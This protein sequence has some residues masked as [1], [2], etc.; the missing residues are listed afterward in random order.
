M[1]R[2]QICRKIKDTFPPIMNIN[3]NGLRNT[4]KEESDASLARELQSTDGTDGRG[5]T[6]MEEYD[7]MSMG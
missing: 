2:Q 7:P 3:N 5:H 1:Y 6:K 4:L